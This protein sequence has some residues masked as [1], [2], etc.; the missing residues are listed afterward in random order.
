MAY[1]GLLLIAVL[2]ALATLWLLQGRRGGW[3]VRGR[4]PPRRADAGGGWAALA[5]GS[6]VVARRR[7]CVLPRLRDGTGPVHGDW[8][9]VTDVTPEA[10]LGR[11]LGPLARA[12]GAAGCVTRLDR[13]TGRRYAALL[14]PEIPVSALVPVPYVHPDALRLYLL[15]AA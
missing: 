5:P 1:V 7:W 15:D 3:V 2:V 12:G 4:P 6:W 13:T 10:A 14:R 11:S 9:D 8:H